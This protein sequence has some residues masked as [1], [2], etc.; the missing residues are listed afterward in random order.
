MCSRRLC[1]LTHETGGNFWEIRY[2]SRY[3]VEHWKRIGVEV[4]F[5]RGPEEAVDAD[6]GLLHLP[7]KVIH[8]AP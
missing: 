5:A 3:L 8:E 1:V 2:L 7:G 6:I 4:S